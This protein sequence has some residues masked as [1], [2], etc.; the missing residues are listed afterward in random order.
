MKRGKTRRV[1]SLPSYSNPWCATDNGN[2]YH[3]LIRFTERPANAACVNMANAHKYKK[4]ANKTFDNR[5]IDRQ[6]FRE[7]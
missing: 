7:K 4:I 6:I 3:H 1:L 2:G 5:S